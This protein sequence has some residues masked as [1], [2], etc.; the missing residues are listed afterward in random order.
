MRSSRGD[1]PAITGPTTIMMV[2]VMTDTTITIMMDT[3][4]MDTDATGFEIKKS[5]GAGHSRA[6]NP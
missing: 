3:I 1:L 5:G 6:A 4:M 2:K